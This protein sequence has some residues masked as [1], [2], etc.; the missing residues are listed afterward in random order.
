MDGPPTLETIRGWISTGT[1]LA[2]LMFVARLWIQNRKLRMEEN[3]DER[4]GYAALIKALTE[5]MTDVR[6]QHKECERRLSSLE[7]Q[8]E[9][10][11]R[12]LVLQASVAAVPLSASPSDD[13][14]DAARR[15]T[16]HVVKKAEESDG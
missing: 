5:D 4:A 14:K 3:V 13:I 7:S 16:L 8:L 11:H 9:G 15:A 12:Q 2:L 1:L 10:V 6:S